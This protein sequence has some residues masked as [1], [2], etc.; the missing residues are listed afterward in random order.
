MTPVDEAL[1]R[2]IHRDLRDDFDEELELELEDRHLDLAAAGA[3][4][5]MASQDKE[6]RRHYFRELFRLQGE[7]V[8]LLSG[9]LCWRLFGHLLQLSTQTLHKSVGKL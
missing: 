1:I 6:S 7:L 2:R 5:D 3:R 4:E 9:S 8:K